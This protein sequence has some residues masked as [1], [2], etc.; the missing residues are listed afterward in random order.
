MQN[1]LTGLERLG[2]ITIPPD[3]DRSQDGFIDS[4]LGP[5]VR[6][7]ESSSDRE[8]IRMLK[9]AN[10]QRN[11]LMHSFLRENALDLCNAAG[12]AA[13]N[14]K[15][16]RTHADIL[17]GCNFAVQASVQIWEA[18]G[19]SRE[20]NERRVQEFMSRV[21]PKPCDPPTTER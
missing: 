5:M 12:C 1:A 14:D 6:I 20:E 7:L 17:A 9:R 10:R 11:V 2:R 3:I 18:L 21:S 8:V 13:T 15:L 19:V 16:Y 4:C